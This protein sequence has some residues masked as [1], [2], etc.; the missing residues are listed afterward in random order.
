MR[1]KALLPDIIAVMAS[2]LVVACVGGLRDVQAESPPAQSLRGNGIGAA[3]AS[4][5]SGRLPDS[6]KLVMN[7]K[8]AGVPV[9][10]LVFSLTS[11]TMDN[12][13]EAYRIETILKTRGI[14]TALCRLDDRYVSFMDKETLC[15]VR[16]ETVS[17]YGS[18]KK[19]TVTTFDQSNHTA[20][21]KDILNGSEKTAAIPPRTQDLVSSFYHL[22]LVSLAEG[23]KFEYDVYNVE[24]YYRLT[25]SVLGKTPVLLPGIGKRQE[26]LMIEPRARSAEDGRLKRGKI[27]LYMSS[28]PQRVLLYGEIDGPLF[29]KVTFTLKHPRHKPA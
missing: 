26:A 24:R 12:G 13:K 14:F 7:V 21:F 8:W 25:Y 17:M 10:V 5:V 22:R 16:H 18:R 4:A 23:D 29:T 19:N 27:R 6:E 9:G 20:R 2:M 28:L 1:I 3:D 11:I 15:S